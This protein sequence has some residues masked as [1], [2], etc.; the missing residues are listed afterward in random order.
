MMCSCMADSSRST[1]SADS[2]GLAHSSRLLMATESGAVWTARSRAMVS[3]VGSTSSVGTARVASPIATPSSAL[4]CRPVSS[5]SAARA[6]PT[7]RGTVQWEWASGITPR[8][9]CTNP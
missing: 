1:S 4:K 2:V 9:T 5:R 8:R 7:A 6:N 3:A